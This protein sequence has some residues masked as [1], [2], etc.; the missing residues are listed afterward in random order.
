MKKGDRV[1][2]QG[3]A[4]TGTI[5]RVVLKNKALFPIKSESYGV[6]WDDGVFSYPLYNS[7]L[8]LIRG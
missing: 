2:F 8:H 4:A 5:V 1:S 3:T 7:D 6:K